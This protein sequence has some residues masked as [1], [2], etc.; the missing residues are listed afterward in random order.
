MQFALKSALGAAVFMILTAGGVGA[1]DSQSG[2][3][4]G[5]QGRLPPGP[6]RVHLALRDI[7][8][9][10][11]AGQRLVTYAVENHGARACVLRGYPQLTLLGRRN[12]R[13]PVTIERSDAG[14]YD[15]TGPAE[16]IVVRPGKRAVFFLK[17]TGIQVTDSPCVEVRRVE[18][19]PR[20]GAKLSIADGLSICTG[21][22]TLTPYRED[23]PGAEY[24]VP[25][26]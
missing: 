22:A 4:S 16:P 13:A 7:G 6:C 12:L 8:I 2:G 10:A 26:T 23:K 24:G 21:R 25:N 9:D 18:V 1:A 20:G 3:Y 5:V 14:F 11:G 17:F 15:L 19:T